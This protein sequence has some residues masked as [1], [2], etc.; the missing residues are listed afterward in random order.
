[1]EKKDVKAVHD[2]LHRFL[3][4]FQF[5]PEFTEEEI[6]HW[7]VHDPKSKEQQVVWSWVVEDPKTHKITDFTSFYLLE[8]LIIKVGKHKTIRAAYSFYY[9]S[10]AAFSPEEKGFKDRLNALTLDTLVLAKEVRTHKI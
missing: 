5:A 4:R 10:E 2:L 7:I 6:E 3:K 8:S 9:A 1:M